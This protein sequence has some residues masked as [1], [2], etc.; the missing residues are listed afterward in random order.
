MSGRFLLIFILMF[1]P[2]LL[3][4]ESIDKL[5]RDGNLKTS[6][7]EIKKLARERNKDIFLVIYEPK[8]PETEAFEK[9]VLIWRHLIEKVPETN[10]VLGALNNE[11]D[12]KSYEIARFANQMKVKN[13]PTVL[14]LDGREEKLYGRIEFSGKREAFWEAFESAKQKKSSLMAAWKTFEKRSRTIL[15]ATVVSGI[16]A[17]MLI[18]AAMVYVFLDG[19]VAF[20]ILLAVMLVDVPLRVFVPYG[21]WIST[22]AWMIFLV[23]KKGFMSF[24]IFTLLSGSLAYGFIKLYATGFVS[25][26]SWL[27]PPPL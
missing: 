2:S 19:E 9:E 16:I 18:T 27:C 5:I 10:F 17:I 12:L 26:I 25:L 24:V 8:K 6:L 14:L 3:S 7:S 23:S 21:V 20:L 15:S 1:L 13:M 22:L 4:A 11:F